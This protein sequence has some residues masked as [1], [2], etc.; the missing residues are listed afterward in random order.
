MYDGSE[1]LKS[2]VDDFN[3]DKVVLRTEK[4][5]AK[6]APMDYD[7]NG[8]TDTVKKMARSALKKRI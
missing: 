1:A 8:S 6:D 4:E 5:M 3:Q 7:D 2:V